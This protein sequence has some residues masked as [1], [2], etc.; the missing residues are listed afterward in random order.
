MALVPVVPVAPNCAATVVMPAAWALPLRVSSIVPVVLLAPSAVVEA[1]TVV[2]PGHVLEGAVSER[3][4]RQAV[5]EQQGI[6][7]ITARDSVGSR[8]FASREDDAV[9]ARA[10][11]ELVIATTAGD[12]AVVAI[13]T[14]DDIVARATRVM[15]SSPAP[16]VRLSLPAPPRMESLPVPPVIV[17]VSAAIVRVRRSRA[18]V[19]ALPSTDFRAVPPP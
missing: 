6:R 12:Q 17:A 14:R 9:I 5:R 4:A 2:M 8:Q 18:A 13:T 15:L 7:A 16:P 19:A 11:V 3:I 10:T 1:V